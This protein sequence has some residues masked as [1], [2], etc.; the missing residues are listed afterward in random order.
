[1]ARSRNTLPIDII[2]KRGFGMSLNK[3]LTPLLASLLF[4]LSAH[5]N[6]FGEVATKAPTTDS[7]AISDST[8]TSSLPPLSPEASSAISSLKIN[9]ARWFLPIRRLKITG[10][11]ILT[12]GATVP[13]GTEITISD[14][15]R[16]NL[17]TVT[18][19]KPNGRWAAFI[20]L[21]Q[22]LVP[23]TLTVSVNTT[24]PLVTTRK[25]DGLDR[26]ICIK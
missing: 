22:N 21:N 24:P 12:S 16:P 9:V 4:L 6:A 8:P 1:M 13:S 3:T 2:V 14:K 18:R 17:T 11:L 5:S 7:R 15:V 10:Q 19:F 23:C 25:V 20:P 26:L